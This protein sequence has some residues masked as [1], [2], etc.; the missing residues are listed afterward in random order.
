MIYMYV[1]R[2][3]H[4]RITY[5]G[6]RHGRCYYF[7][8]DFVFSRRGRR[9]KKT[10]INTARLQTEIRLDR[11]S[12]RAEAV[13]YFFI[14][15]YGKSNNNDDNHN[16]W[17]IL[18]RLVPTTYLTGETNIIMKRQHF[19]GARRPPSRRSHDGVR[20]RTG[21]GHRSDVVVVTAIVEK[22]GHGGL[23]E[24][25][26]AR[27]VRVWKDK[28]RRTFARRVNVLYYYIE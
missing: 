8:T 6:S 22:H 1:R 10:R 18:V 23:L 13:W 20:T 5:R 2:K 12:R 27:R 3:L 24:T 25:A 17:S 4:S 11:F 14:F 7:T 28:S 21:A 9:G 26:A 15:F 19:R 16:K